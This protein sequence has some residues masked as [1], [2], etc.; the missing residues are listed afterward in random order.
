MVMLFVGRWTFNPLDSFTHPASA[1]GTRSA[2]QVW[3]ENLQVFLFFSLFN[4]VNLKE[5]RVF[6]SLILTDWMLFSVAAHPAAASVEVSTPASKHS[7]SIWNQWVSWWTNRKLSGPFNLLSWFQTLST[8]L[9]MG[10]F[11]H[12]LIH[13]CCW[14]VFLLN[15]LWSRLVL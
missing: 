10:A 1:A 11:T 2:L 13:F 15:F 6:L 12:S 5:R 8:L 14:S 9:M 4:Y 3:K 7:T